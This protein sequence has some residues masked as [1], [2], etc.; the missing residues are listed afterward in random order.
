MASTS[1]ERLAAAC[2]STRAAGLVKLHGDGDRA[3]TTYVPDASFDSIT[4]SEASAGMLS[5]SN[6]GRRLS[7]RRPAALTGSCGVVAHAQVKQRAHVLIGHAVKPVLHGFRARRQ[8]ASLLLVRT[9]ARTR[10]DRRRRTGG[11]CR[12]VHV[13]GVVCWRAQ[14]SSG[15][16]C[17]SSKPHGSCRAA[18]MPGGMLPCSSGCARALRT[19]LGS[20]TRTVGTARVDGLAASLAAHQP[21]LTP[22]GG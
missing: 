5:D 20:H 3:Y 12:D 10:P 9:C 14:L 19:R 1:P 16:S 17:R 8:F 15:S 13:R 6:S 21:W 22:R 2:S 7:V 4:F 18:S 11:C